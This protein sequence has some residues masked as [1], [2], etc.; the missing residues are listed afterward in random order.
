MAYMLS[1]IPNFIQKVN[2]L[3]DTDNQ[4]FNIVEYSTKSNEQYKI[5]RYRKEL[6]AADLIPVYGLLRSVVINKENIVVSFA[7]PKSMPAD[8]FMEFI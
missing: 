1:Y 8:K 6:L 4:Y 7:P 2:N 3:I 5:A